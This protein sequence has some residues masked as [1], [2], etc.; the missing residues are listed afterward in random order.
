MEK[1]YS[2]YRNDLDVGTL[3]AESLMLLNRSRGTYEVDQPHVQK[4][5]SVLEAILRRDV[6]HP[7]AC[8]LYIHATEATR[9]PDKAEN[10]AQ[11]LGGTIP[12]ASHINH[13][14]SHTFNRVGRWGDAVRANIDAWHT[15][16]RAGTGDAVAIGPTHNLQ[17]LLFA[18]SYDG[19]GAIATQ[20][21]RDYAK[22]VPSGTQ[23]I[24][25]TLLR[26]GRFD[27]V[28]ALQRA[29]SAEGSR[30][31][32]EFARGY[33]HLRLNSS[34]SARFYL[35]RLDGG[36]GGGGRTGSLV[37]IVRGILRGELLRSEGQL[38]E[39]IAALEAAVAVED[40]L[41]YAEPE[42]LPFS[43]R[44]WLGAMLLEAKRPGD[45]EGVYT[46]DLV[47]HPRNGWSLHGLSQALSE[48]GRTGEAAKVR[49]E[50]E[51]SWSR[52][53]TLLRGSRF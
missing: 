24:A 40:D 9:R 5:H 30:L 42:P 44:H 17:M 14:P 52:S 15:D 7:G 16:M 39:A 35:A 45:A 6:R 20:A 50:L 8:H 21:A 34:D 31:L 47:R 37:T 28:L 29:P 46:D 11:Y 38:A 49:T 48:Q 32:W 12:G 43:A 2:Q 3:Y 18:A 27:E 33:S 53:D 41:S 25:L 23:H 1:L 13:M 36:S 19:Q 10:C 22:L 26:F 4:F 51:E